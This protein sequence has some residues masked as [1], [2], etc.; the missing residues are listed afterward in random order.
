MSKHSINSMYKEIRVAISQFDGVGCSNRTKAEA[1][2]HLIDYTP[3]QLYDMTNLKDH[4]STVWY[5]YWVKGWSM[6]DICT[7]LNMPITLVR[8][9]RYTAA[10]R[11]AST[12]YDMYE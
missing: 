3:E 2:A 12:L 1:C 9:K 10:K 4:S 5:L 7:I 8:S 11:I 6:N